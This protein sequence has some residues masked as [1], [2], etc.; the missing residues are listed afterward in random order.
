[1]KHTVAVVTH[2]HVLQNFYTTW[3]RGVACQRQR[4]GPKLAGVWAR[5][6][7]KKIGTPY[8]FLQPLKLATS[9][10]VHN[11]GLG[12]AY[13]KQRLAQKLAGVW[14]KGASKQNLGPPTYFCNR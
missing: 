9:N 2:A 8:L 3:V 13:Q 7:F 11:L 5:E 10:L 14:A 1:M 12:L 4:L 6:A